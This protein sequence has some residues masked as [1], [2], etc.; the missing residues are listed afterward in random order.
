MKIRKYYSR[1]MAEG[2]QKI[3]KELGPEAIILQ[4]RNVRRRGL[5]GWFAPHQIEIIAAL[6]S[7]GMPPKNQDHAVETGKMESELNELKTMVKMLMKENSRQEPAGNPGGEDKGD[8]W[9]SYLQHH[10]VDPAIIDEMVAQVAAKCEGTTASKEMQ[11]TLLQEQITARIPAAEERT[12]RTIVLIGPTGVGKTTTLA[13]LAA[14]YSIQCREK[15]GLV[16]IDQFRIGAVDQLSAYAEIIDLPL[17]VAFSPEDLAQAI[18][19]L[20]DCDRI[21]VDTAGR[22]TGNLAQTN[23]LLNYIEVLLP[24]EVHLVISATTRWQDIRFITDSFSRLHYNRLLVTKLDET[25]SYGAI[26]N[27][28][29]HA[30]QPLVYM[31]DGQS[32]PDDL[33]LARE[34]NFAGYFWG[35]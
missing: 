33:K 3:K 20:K 29:Y 31:T 26:L 2:F 19:G 4:T 17:K 21:L 25:S 12:N 22:A 32:V 30:G 28:A 35:E 16:T 7:R 23:E 13:K 18:D 9:R 5:K 27:G 34:N 14:R 15:V 11:A 24:A 6:D 8:C 1:D 10:D